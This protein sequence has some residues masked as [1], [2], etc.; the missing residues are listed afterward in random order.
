[1]TA[2]TDFAPM[3]DATGYFGPYGGQLVP[4]HLKQAMDDINAAYAEIT[5]RQDFQ[6]ELAQLFADYVGRP[7]PIFHAKRLSAQLGGAQIHL[8]REDLNHTGA[9][10]INHCLGEALLAKF[11][12]KK[13]VIAETGAGQH[14][15]ALATACALVGIPCEIHMG[16][17]DIEK[18]H[19]NVTK[20]RILGCKLVPVTRG[21]ATLKEAVDSAFEEYLTNPTDYIYAIGSVVGPHPFPMMVR[22]FQS[23]IGREAREQ[24]QARHGKL[25]NYVT[26]CV[27]GGSNA[28]GMFTAF[29]NDT[30]VKLVGV[31]PSGEGTDK[32]GRHAATLSMGKPG[33]IHG[34]KCYVLEDAPGVPAAV[35]S[36][37]SGLDY[38]GVGP[39]HSYLKDIGRVQYESVTDKECLDAFMQLSRVEGIIPALESAHAVAWAMRVAPTL[40]KDTHILVNLSGRGDKDADYVAK[41]LGI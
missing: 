6:D 28:M 18:E 16:Q 31:E 29:L 27:G 23:I 41:L 17:V 26:A 7:S 37:A 25:P 15:V 1:M 40:S 11:M 39:Q 22:D 32:P 8:K 2:S 9:H 35:H 3:P 13:K 12:G 10:K 19:P 24:F 30:S 5:Q 14:G 4:P 21:A 20:M 36:I 34:M 33:E 38:P